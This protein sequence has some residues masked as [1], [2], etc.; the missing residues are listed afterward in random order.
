MFVSS[1]KSVFFII[2]LVVSSEAFSLGG[3]SKCNSH[4]PQEAS[5]ELLLGRGA[6]LQSSFATI[7]GISIISTSSPA[8][9]KTVDPKLKDT[10]DDPAY[11]NCISK[12][13]YECTKPKGDEQKSRS[14]CLPECKQKC[15]TSKAQ[16]MIG[17]PKSE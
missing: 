9:A 16:L 10:K 14:E 12:C 13:V 15:A 11:Q 4:S 17:T 8:Y 2:G 5:N 6:F 3:P 1:L 7:A